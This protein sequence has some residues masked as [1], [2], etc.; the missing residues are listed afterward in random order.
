MKI[1][2]VVGRNTLINYAGGKAFQ[3]RK[4]SL[5]EREGKVLLLPFGKALSLPCRKA[6]QVG[7]VEVIDNSGSLDQL[8]KRVEKLWRTRFGRI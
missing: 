6:K 8:R 4:A 3:I 2:K 7:R 1:Y 5:F